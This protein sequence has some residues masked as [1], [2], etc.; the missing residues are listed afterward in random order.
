MVDAA[1]GGSPE[2]VQGYVDDYGLSFPVLNDRDVIGS[3]AIGV[4]SQIPFYVLLNRDMT[5]AYSGG[6]PPM[7]S[8]FEE[9]LE[10]EWPEVEYPQNPEQI[11]I[12]GDDDDDGG[13]ESVTPVDNPFAVDPITTWE[14]SNAC[15]VG[16][17]TTPPYAL[18][19]LL[20]LLA[21]RRRR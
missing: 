8:K 12:E 13:G 3:T 6:S 20:P 11:D 21:L 5:I 17:T 18:L 14:A 7:P 10:E 4:Q 15:S 2:P 16:G 9:A 1:T 19:A